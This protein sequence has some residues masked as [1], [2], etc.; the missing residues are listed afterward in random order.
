M[1]V[2]AVPCHHGPMILQALDPS[3]EEHLSGMARDGMDLFLLEKGSIRASVLHA[4][5]MVN[6]MRRNHRTGILETVALAYAYMGGLLAGSTLKG[7][8]RMNISMDCE[9]PLRGFSVD[10][11]A[12]G[13]VRGYLKADHI[14]LDH[15]LDSFDLAP[16]IGA[17]SLTVTRHTGDSLQPFSGTVELAHGSIA[18]DLARYFLLSEQ[19]PTALSLSVYFD[20]RGEVMGAG[21]LLI[22]A[23]PDASEQIREDLDDWLAEIPSL[24]RMFSENRTGSRIMH[25]VFAAFYPDQVGSRDVSF[26]CSCSREGF[27]AY[28]RSLPEK[29]K[30]ALRDHDPHKVEVVCHNCGTSYSFPHQEMDKR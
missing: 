10:A 21:G 6:E 17:G 3:M 30:I 15:P 8:D 29:E 22:Q 12:S 20:A 27:L 28:L 2:S 23:M 9:G 24:G 5:R 26:H 16:F 14:P 19:I 11:N 13:Q 25:E 7:N 18:L 4:S 1:T